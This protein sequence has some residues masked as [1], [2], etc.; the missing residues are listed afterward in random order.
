MLAEMRN[1]VGKGFLGTHNHQDL[2]ELGVPN[3]EDYR[4]PIK[5]PEDKPKPVGFGCI[6][7]SWHPRLSYAGTYDEIWQKKRAP[8][9]PHDF[10][11]RFFHTAH[12]DLIFGKYLK[13]GEPVSM[14]NMSPK[15]KQRFSLPICDLNIAVSIDGK[16][17]RPK[18]NLE[19]VL[20][21]PTDDKCCLSWRAAMPCDKK[22]LKV[23]QINVELNELTLDRQGG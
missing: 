8:Y 5:S 11:Q 18:V 21:E 6:S 9:L 15:R 16:I 2:S 20:L 19:T 7:P 14:T 4:N 13:G 17:E 1:P 22:A 10:D 3:I 12:P 23:S